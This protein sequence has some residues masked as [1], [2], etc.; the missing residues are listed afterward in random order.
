[1]LV[2]NRCDKANNLITQQIGDTIK[3]QINIT[4]KNL[5]EQAPLITQKISNCICQR[6]NL[7]RSVLVFHWVSKH[8][9][10]GESTLPNTYPCFSNIYLKLNTKGTTFFLALEFISVTCQLQNFCLMIN[11]MPHLSLPKPR[12]DHLKHSFEY[13]GAFLWNNLPEELC[14]TNSLDLFKRS[15]NK[16]VFCITANM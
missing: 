2:S 13:S 14:T 4:K 16:M 5:S 3:L 9:K 8:K 15:I 12:T 10:T 7:E 6:S 11:M 1:M